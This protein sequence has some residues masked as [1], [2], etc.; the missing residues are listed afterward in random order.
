MPRLATRGA[1]LFHRRPYQGTR[2]V[3]CL[4]ASLALLGAARW[5]RWRADLSDV[6]TAL[7]TPLPRLWHG[8]EGG[9]ARWF[10]AWRSRRRL[11]ARVRALERETLRLRARL[12]T[13]R[14]LGLEDR[15]LRRILGL[16]RRLGV[17][18]VAVPILRLPRDPYPPRMLLA[19][20]RAAGL[21]TGMPVLDLRGLVGV[22][23]TVRA[24]SALVH[25][26]VTRHTLVPVED[27]RSRLLTFVEGTGRLHRLSLPF[28]PNG[29][30]IRRGDLLVTSGVGGVYPPGYPVA[31]VT[32]V[33]PEPAYAFARVEARPLATPFRDRVVVVLLRAPRRKTEVAKRPAAGGAGTPP[34]VP[35]R[36]ETP[37]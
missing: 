14:A 6:E 12:E 34:S 26:V 7:S 17:R 19:R 30:D 11:V 18:A 13:E 33:E 35:P 16:R 25:L 28:V 29:S 1:G 21:A 3:L 8:V 37:P 9:T 5:A 10:D 2:L 22:V 24:R 36:K 20:G 15:R 31:V 4:L 23:T 27:L 32:R